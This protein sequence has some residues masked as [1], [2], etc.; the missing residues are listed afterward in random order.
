M[1]SRCTTRGLICQ[2]SSREPRPRGPSK[3]RLRNAISSLDLRPPSKTNND[4]LVQQGPHRVQGH[5]Q[6]SMLEHRACFEN[7]HLEHVHRRASMPQLNRDFPEFNPA[8]S[9]P[10]E[11]CGMTMLGYEPSY[12]GGTATQPQ[13]FSNHKEHHLQQPWT[14]VRCI[15]THFTLDGRNEEDTAMQFGLHGPP[16]LPMVGSNSYGSFSSRGR[17]SPTFQ[18]PL[19]L[20]ERA[21]VEHFEPQKTQHIEQMY[22]RGYHSDSSSSGYEVVLFSV[23]FIL[24]CTRTGLLRQNL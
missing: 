22:S 3:A 9:A 20:F 14:D 21:A 12:A 16:P 6:K 17:V 23:T 13:Q 2:Y 1:C 19:P 7:R 18:L 11:F 5:S 24:N 15:Q 8:G 4:V 10:R